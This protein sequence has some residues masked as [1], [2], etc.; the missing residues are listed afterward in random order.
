MATQ[1]HRSRKH[2][3][4]GE[5]E[6]RAECARLPGKVSGRTVGDIEFGRHPS[7]H[8]AV[9]GGQ[10]YSGDLFKGAPKK[11]G[12]GAALIDREAKGQVVH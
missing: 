10:R 7:R 9:S 2:N 5:L 8:N 4:E 11:R 1:K 3:M 6:L 12:A